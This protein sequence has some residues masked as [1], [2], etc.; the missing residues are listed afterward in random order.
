MSSCRV[1]IVTGAG[2]GIGR[3]AAQAL[4]R[5]EFRVNLA[6]HRLRPLE[7]TAS[8]LGG[9]PSLIV[10]TEVTHPV[11]VDGLFEE[12]VAAFRRV[13]LLFTNA[14]LSPKWG[15]PFGSV[16]TVGRKEKAE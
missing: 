10:P 14:G 13:G 9:A 16:G 15:T 1:A 3:P 12:A 4:S 11:S 5:D 8:L 2:G 6:G 7:V